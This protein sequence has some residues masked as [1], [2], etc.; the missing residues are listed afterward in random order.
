VRDAAASR[1][2]WWV[3]AA[4][5][6]IRSLPAGRYR[7]MNLVARRR[8]PPFWAQLP[9]EGGGLVFRCDLRDPLMREACLTGCYEP[10]ESMLVSRMLRPAMTFVDVGANWGYFTLLGAHLVGGTGRI[11][12][13][14]ADPRACD[15]L[16]ENVAANGLAQV[17]VVGVAAGDAG[18]MLELHAY[19]SGGGSHGNFG[20]ALAPARADGRRF[21]IQSRAL[22]DV[23]D[24]A[25]VDH[26]DLLKMDIEGGEW[27]GVHGLER[28]LRAGRL[29]RIILELHPEYLAAQH[30]S[31]ADV[32]A[33]LR[34]R[35]YD[36][37]RIE[38]SPRAHRRA[39]A[40][41]ARA[42]TLL[43]PLDRSDGRLGA[44]P[45]VLFVRSGLRPL[46]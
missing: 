31:C 26:V 39:A 27:R 19:G 38:H 4:S 12:S 23:L 7:A 24:E 45:H 30:V 32:I 25:G 28:R 37:W 11:V 43:A 22:D 14:E 44:W 20:V 42:D 36:A 21:R 46:D 18:G 15:A 1:A 10:Q 40:G 17:S 16:R 34:H 29:D 41:S 6:V 2:P 5:R 3:A 13:V 8:H 33:H 9:P 35:G